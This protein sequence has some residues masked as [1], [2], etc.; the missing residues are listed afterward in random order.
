MNMVRILDRETSIKNKTIINIT[1]KLAYK[2]RTILMRTFI[3]LIFQEVL[4][5]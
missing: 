3:K 1:T 2:K 4:F 5:T